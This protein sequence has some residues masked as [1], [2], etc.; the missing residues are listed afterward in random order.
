MTTEGHTTIT[1]TKPS[2]PNRGPTEVRGD[3]A[4]EYLKIG[5]GL[6]RFCIPWLFDYTR[7]LGYV[8]TV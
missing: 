6:K 3:S 8:K 1:I 2:H 5:M 4:G 7:T